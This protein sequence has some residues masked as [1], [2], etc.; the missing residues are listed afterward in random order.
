MF[1][2]LSL[3]QLKR[4]FL[5]NYIL[6]ATKLNKPSNFLVLVLFW[7]FVI[8]PLCTIQARPLAS[9][10]LHYGTLRPSPAGGDQLSTELAEAL[11]EDLDLF[12][13]KKEGPSNG[14]EG[15]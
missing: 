12:G 7:S 15:H 5:L 11:L 10:H 8:M 1:I 14:G 3:H 2:Y 6:M 9:K 4:N 13:I